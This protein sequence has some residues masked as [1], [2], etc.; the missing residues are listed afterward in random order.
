[1][2][3]QKLGEEKVYVTYMSIT[4]ENHYRRSSRQ[5]PGGRNCSR[6]HRSTLLTGLLSLLSYTEQAHLP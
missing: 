4:E 1:M 3:K 5:E 6:N 2:T